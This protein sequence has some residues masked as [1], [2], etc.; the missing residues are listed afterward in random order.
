MHLTSNEFYHIYN[1]G[2]NKHPIFFNHENYLFFIKKLRTQLLPVSS[3]ISY[4][5]MPNHFHLI[6]MA[7]EAGLI[8]RPT[9]GGKSM[10]E[11]SYRLGILLSSYSQ[12]INKQNKTIGSLFQQKTRS[13][14]LYENV[15][16]RKESYLEACFFYV[17][18][19]PLEAGLVTELNKW[20]Y[21]SYP[22][23]AGLRNGSLCDKELFYKY[24]GLKQ[25]DILKRNSTGFTKEEID[26]FY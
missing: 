8:E 11:F 24:S 25:E 3:I 22:D 1:R 5:L 2:N 10:H 9:F 26:K 15:N 16:G 23:Y 19:N 4:C 20:P 14:H 17:H 13:K 12:A 7:K 6:V 18:Q 21:S